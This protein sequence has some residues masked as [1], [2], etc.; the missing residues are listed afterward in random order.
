M[1]LEASRQV[2][3]TEA[4]KNIWPTGK[5]ILEYANKSHTTSDTDRRPA[6]AS[7]NSYEFL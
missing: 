5:I 3:M 2:S 7:I 6:F 1:A 4:N